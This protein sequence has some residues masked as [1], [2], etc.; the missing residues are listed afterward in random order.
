MRRRCLMVSRVGFLGGV[1]R[2]ALTLA[3]GLPGLGWKA[4]LACPDGGAL[5]EAA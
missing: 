3:T 5:A 2:I 1:E 4:I